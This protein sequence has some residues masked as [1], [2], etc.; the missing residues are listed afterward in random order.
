LIGAVEE[1]M[2]RQ[3]M[4]RPLEAEPLMVGLISEVLREAIFSM[5]LMQ[6]RNMKQV[7]VVSDPLSLSSWS[8]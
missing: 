3:S 7:L 1:A 4:A 5:R 8:M 6:A 2:K